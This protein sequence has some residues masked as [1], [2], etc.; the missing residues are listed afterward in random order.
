MQLCSI[1]IHILLSCRSILTDDLCC[2]QSVAQFTPILGSEAILLCYLA[3]FN[4]TFEYRQIHCL[5]SEIFHRNSFLVAAT[6]NTQQ[7][8]LHIDGCI[9]TVGAAA[10]FGGSSAQQEGNSVTQI[11]LCS[12][13]IGHLLRSGFPGNFRNKSEWMFG[14]TPVIAVCRLK[15]CIGEGISTDTCEVALEILGQCVQLAFIAPNE[16]VLNTPAISGIAHN[17]FITALKG[18]KR[19][20]GLA[21]AGDHHIRTGQVGNCLIHGVVGVGPV[22]VLHLSYRGVGNQQAV[23]HTFSDINQRLFCHGPGTGRRIGIGHTDA[24]MVS[25][26]AIG[27]V[28][29]RRIGAHEVQVI[30]SVLLA[31]NHGR[32][33]EYLQIAHAIPINRRSIG[34][35]AVR[36]IQRHALIHEGAVRTGGSGIAKLGIDGPVIG[37]SLGI[38]PCGENHIVQAIR[39]LGNCCT[40]NDTAVQFVVIVFGNCLNDLAEITVIPNGSFNFVV[41]IEFQLKLT[42]PVSVIVQSLGNIALIQICINNNLNLLG[43]EI[44]RCTCDSNCF[45]I[46]LKGAYG[47]CH[48]FLQLGQ[49]SFS[50][51]QS[52]NVGNQCLLIFSQQIVGSAGCLDGLFAF[53][54]DFANGVDFLSNC[55]RCIQF[56]TT[57][58]LILFIVAVFMEDTIN[59]KFVDTRR[60]FCVLFH[61]KSDFLTVNSFIKSSGNGSCTSGSGVNLGPAFTVIDLNSKAVDPGGNTI[62]TL[63]EL[64]N[65]ETVH[66][67]VALQING[68][69][70]FGIRNLGS[71]ASGTVAIY[72]LVCKVIICWNTSSSMSI[73]I[74]TRNRLI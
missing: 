20:V 24:L 12:F 36:G 35:V 32:V 15:Q 73:S 54:R 48:F 46:A 3:S 6:H 23:I 65:L 74:G 44:D 61:Y 62:A 68:K 1:E 58:T 21:A 51:F 8:D 64:G 56:C 52:R 53:Q 4:C 17:C 29:F 25:A 9:A 34:G 33:T 45:A 72:C 41:S 18:T 27:V 57:C 71:P 69:N 40:P 66:L 28:S 63:L 26:I 10:V 16:A 50:S 22:F 11:Q 31:V 43:T 67:V 49:C 47:H 59:F 55:L 37:K 38:V 2:S 60:D 39:A 42:L 14:D 30:F 19:T 5:F 13:Q 70:T 7:R